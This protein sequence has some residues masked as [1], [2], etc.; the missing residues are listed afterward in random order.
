MQN[1]ITSLFRLLDRDR[2]VRTATDFP[3]KSVGRRVA[4]PKRYNVASYISLKKIVERTFFVS[5]VLC[6]RYQYL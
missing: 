4:L 3:P 1:Y 6:V 2:T 5:L